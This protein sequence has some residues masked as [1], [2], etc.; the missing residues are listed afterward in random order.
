MAMRAVTVRARPQLLGDAR[1]LSD[2]GRRFGDGFYELEAR[3]LIAEEWATT[4]ED[5]WMRR[6]KHALHMSEAECAAF[7]DWM[8][9][10]AP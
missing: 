9:K 7:A 8:R 2:L 3:Y 1:S 4:A 5:I 10:G 6:T